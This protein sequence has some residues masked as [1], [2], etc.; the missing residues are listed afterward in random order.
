MKA[1]EKTEQYLQGMSQLAPNMKPNNVL[2]DEITGAYDVNFT[3]INKGATPANSDSKLG[4]G[5][6]STVYSAVHKKTGV[7]ASILHIL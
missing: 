7:C 6:Y 3:N 1:H 4:S 5:A 2:L